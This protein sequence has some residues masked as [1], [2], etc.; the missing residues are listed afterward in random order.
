MVPFAEDRFFCEGLYFLNP[1][2]DAYL[3]G[4]TGGLVATITGRT[5]TIPDLIPSSSHWLVSWRFYEVCARF[6]AQMCVKFEPV[7][8]NKCPRSLSEVRD[9][10]YVARPEIGAGQHLRDH[11][12]HRGHH[13]CAS[14]H[15]RSALIQ[16]GLRVDFKPLSDFS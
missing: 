14:Q 12:E 16:A 4:K 9:R 7:A 3:S 10:F 6:D 2:L 13:L 1:G 11:P 5:K 8:V 15:M